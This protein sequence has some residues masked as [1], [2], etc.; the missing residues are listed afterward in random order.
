MDLTQSYANNI[1]KR[2]NPKTVLKM[3][4]AGLKVQCFKL[5]KFP[6]KSLPKSLQ[7]LHYIGTKFILDSLNTPNKTVLVN[8]LAPVEILH[9]MDLNPLFVEGISSFLSGFQI[10]DIYID[11]AEKQGVSETLCSYHKIFLGA[12]E[13]EIIPKPLMALT[14]SSICDANINSFR[15]ISEK[16]KLPLYIL[17]I[18]HNYSKKN[19]DYVVKQLKEFISLIEKVSNKKLDLNKL[20]K[21]LEIEN[22]TKQ[23]F[24][25]FLKELK[26]RYFPNTL[27]SEMFKFMISHVFM[28]KKETLK[29][30]K[31]LTND[32]KT[33]PKS[34][35]KR[36]MWCHVIPY[37]QPDLKNF[38]DFSKEHQLLVEDFTYDYLEELDINNPLRAL[39]K[40]MLLNMFNGDYERRVEK[41]TKMSKY[42]NADA[43]INFCH[44]G[45][46]QS[47]GG[48]SLLR[49][50]LEK[51]ILNLFQLMVMVLIKE[52]LKHTN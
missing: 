41:I 14:T 2:Q 15:H 5:K 20:K 48:I 31:M 50:S 19:E 1:K 38:F 22:Q 10:E 28:G 26:T 9:A 16:Y 36:I 49:D 52:I 21:V 47:I 12:V 44:W 37:Y 4:K 18:P 39:A 30:Y 7:Y 34:T 23:Y 46:K 8:L 24:K 25:E 17:D 11:H 32:I 33:F 45:C 35:G 40:K 51:T 6:N 3:I 27:T 43:L 13:K 42:L 29:F